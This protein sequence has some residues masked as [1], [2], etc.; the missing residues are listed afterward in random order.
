[1]GGKTY[2][3]IKRNKMS[4]IVSIDDV[5][6]SIRKKDCLFLWQKNIIYQ[7]TQTIY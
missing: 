3:L 4:C 2:K 6:E 1:M 5:I 7:N